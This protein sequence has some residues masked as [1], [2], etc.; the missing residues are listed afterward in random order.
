M[1]PCHLRLGASEMVAEDQAPLWA[2]LPFRHWC[3]PLSLCSLG[4]CFG[5][6]FATVMLKVPEMLPLFII[7]KP[8][9]KHWVCNLE[10]LITAAMEGIFSL[11]LALDF[12]LH[13]R[14]LGHVLV[15]F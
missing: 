4:L 11:E 7:I 9:K 3:F 14:P 12:T 2:R 13:P 5:F 8:K 6:S 15:F 10:L 1:S